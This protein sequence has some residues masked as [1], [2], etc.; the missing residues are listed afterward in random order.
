MIELRERI[1]RYL[2]TMEPSVSG[3]GGHARCFAA[4][5]ALV[6]G[7]GLDEGEAMVVLGADFNPRCSPPW[8]DKELRHK[9]RSAMSADTGGKV[10]GWLRGEDGGRVEVSAKPWQRRAQA[11]APAKRQEFRAEVLRSV[12]AE[13]GGDW[14]GFLRSRSPVDPDVGPE[15][16]LRA[17][18]R[19]GERV[20]VF[21][22]ERSQGDWGVDIRQ[23]RARVYE[24]GDRPGV[25]PVAVERLPRGGKNGLWFLSQPVT[26]QW[27]PNGGVTDRGDAKLSRR[28]TPNVTAWRYLVLESDEADPGEWCAMLA[29]LRLPISAVYESG[30]RSV[31]ALVYTESAGLAEWNAVRDRIVPYLARLGGDLG[32]TSAVRLTRLPNVMRYGKTVRDGSYERFAEPRLQRLLWLTGRPECRRIDTLPRLR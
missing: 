31:H 18:Y 32:A 1:R 24:L 21:R 6:Q 3:S 30:G 19:P 27:A 25:A 20:L 5:V 26:G 14:R 2:A 29:G 23:Q 16:F 9:V 12:G 8:S 17:L 15:E 13:I 10:R 4:A 22:S 7:W 11:E 28:S